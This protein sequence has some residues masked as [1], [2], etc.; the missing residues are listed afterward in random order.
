MVNEQASGIMIPIV[1]NFTEGG[2][3]DGI[4][5]IIEDAYYFL[6]DTSNDGTPL[7]FP[8]IALAFKLDIEGRD[9]SKAF[10][11]LFS[12]GTKSLEHY[13][14]SNADGTPVAD[15]EKRA[16]F[17]VGPYPNKQCAYAM[18]MQS[19]LQAGWPQEKLMPDGNAAGLVGAVVVWKEVADDR[20]FGKDTDKQK[21][22]RTIKLVD[23]IEKYPWT[24]EKPSTAAA[25]GAAPVANTP[26]ATKGRPPAAEKSAKVESVT[27]AAPAPAAEANPLLDLFASL[28]QAIL[29]TI[30]GNTIPPAI[31]V[32]S[33]QK[34]ILDP[35][36]WTNSGLEL[37]AGMTPAQFA[38]KVMPKIM[39]DKWLK[40]R[41][42]FKYENMT[43]SL[44]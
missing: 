3:L 29:L 13:R 12:L 10:P 33:V 32:K 7:E 11:Q 39:D 23:Y 15:G 9:E 40:S 37:P 21:K 17:I 2:F 6:N 5:S 35:E 19:L 42:E 43:L 8:N 31:K 44:A 1:S 25:A 20:N 34:A 24:N 18:L 27:Q 4:K 22:T 26:R 38:Q 14:L 28:I 30:D 41:D 16:N 36:F